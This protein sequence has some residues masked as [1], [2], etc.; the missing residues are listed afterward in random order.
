MEDPTED[1]ILSELSPAEIALIVDQLEE[2]DP[3]NELLPAGYRQANQT[4]KKEE[5]IYDREALLEYLEEQARSLPEQEEF[6][7]HIQGQKRGKIFKKVERHQTYSVLEPD[8]EEALKDID[9]ADLSE[10]AD[11]LGE[12]CIQSHVELGRK[13]Y[14]GGEDAGLRRIYRPDYR[15]PVDASDEPEVN[16]ANVD[17]DLRSVQEQDPLVT[18]VNWNNLRDTPITTIQA[19][20]RALEYNEYVREVSISNTRANDLI[21]LSICSC[22]KNNAFIKKLNIESNFISSKQMAD[23]V[24][25][26]CQSPSMVELRIDNQRNKFGETTENLFCD[27]L[28]EG[29]GTIQKFSYSWRCP[30]PR[31]RSEHI[32]M[33]HRDRSTRLKRVNDLNKL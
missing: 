9:G 11:I 21:G 4:D 25:L 31:S 28:A 30:G 1:I 33:K 7:P 27:S 23:V 22:I 10:L 12:S 3:D 18:I 15:D 6:M 26:C 29:S 20:F 8:I 16:P 17:N 13:G 14:E 5:G 24:H 19:L 2:L 32:L